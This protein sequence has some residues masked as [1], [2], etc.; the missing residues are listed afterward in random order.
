MDTQPPPAAATALPLALQQLGQGL[1]THSLGPKLA[2]LSTTNGHYLPLIQ[3]Y[4]STRSLR[5]TGR[6]HRYN[7]SLEL[8]EL[9]Q[10]QFMQ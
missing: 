7:P 8:L 1:D 3:L 5:S 6:K 4:S 9:V 10:E 2:V